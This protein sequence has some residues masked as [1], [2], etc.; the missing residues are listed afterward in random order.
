MVTKTNHV[1]KEHH[2]HCKTKNIENKDFFMVQS[3]IFIFKKGFFE[4]FPDIEVN[5]IKTNSTIKYSFQRVDLIGMHHFFWTV[6]NL[7]QGNK[8]KDNKL[9]I[10]NNRD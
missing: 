3:F 1:A 7:S 9:E 6:A 8:K 2:R 10:L 5:A 4:N